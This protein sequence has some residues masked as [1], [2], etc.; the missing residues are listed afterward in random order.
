VGITV[1]KNTIPFDQQG[2]FVTSGIRIGT[3]TVTT[4]GMQAP[5]MQTI[6]GLIVDVLT[7]SRDS[8]VIQRSRE[9]VQA[10]CAAFPIYFDGNE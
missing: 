8:A 6:A 9:T 7:H 5:E 2:P 1:N 4:R 10:L 3:P